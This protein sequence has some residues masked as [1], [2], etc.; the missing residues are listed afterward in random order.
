M[1]G[2]YTTIQV[3]EHKKM[4]LCKNHNSDFVFS[5]IL[6]IYRHSTCAIFQHELFFNLK[7]LRFRKTL[8]LSWKIQKTNSVLHSEQGEKQRKKKCL[9][10][11]TF[12]WKRPKLFVIISTQRKNILRRMLKLRFNKKSLNKKNHENDYK[13]N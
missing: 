9:T 12:N 11:K 1:N 8:S 13:R 5:V 7:F 2:E 10:E 3:S 6:K 4:F